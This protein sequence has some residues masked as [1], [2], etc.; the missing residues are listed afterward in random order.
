MDKT[1][2]RA[3]VRSL[4][5]RALPLS[6]AGSLLGLM[7]AAHEG[8]VAGWVVALTLLTTGLLQTL[9][10]VSNEL[11]DWLSGLD[12]DG[13]KGPAYSMQRG[14]LSEKDM[15]R[16]ILVLAIACCVTGAAMTWASFGTWFALEP[17]LILALGACA[18][19]AAMH[20]TLGKN[21]YGYHALGDL[22]VFIFFGL[23][24]VMGARY[25]ANHQLGPWT[26][27]LPAI[28]IGCFSISVLNVN[29]IRDIVSDREGGRLTIAMQFGGRGARIYHT[30]LIVVGWLAM[31]LYTALTFTSVWNLLYVV[32]LP[33]FVLHI[34]GMWKR[35]GKALDP[36][37]PMLV[38]SSFA[39]AVLASVGMMIE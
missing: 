8:P 4:R 25:V 11:G 14:E 24:P 30:I 28:A 6:L 38:M 1:K 5:L 27:V 9:S 32:T 31:L 18:I 19:W 23:V 2:T 33:L 10:N 17:L 13:R 35:D 22:F 20:Y 16:C 37:L 21:P 15:R 7:I 39:F 3:L 36:L 29:N 12:R 26:I 34:R